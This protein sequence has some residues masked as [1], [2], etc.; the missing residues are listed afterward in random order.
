MDTTMKYKHLFRSFLNKE[1]FDREENYISMPGPGSYELDQS[2]IERRL[3][4]SYNKSRAATRADKTRSAKGISRNN[5][6]VKTDMTFTAGFAHGKSRNINTVNT[7]MVIVNNGRDSYIL[8]SQFQTQKVGPGDYHTNVNW[9]E[10]SYL[11]KRKNE[12]DKMKHN[13]GPKVF[14]STWSIPSRKIKNQNFTGVGND[15]PGPNSYQ[16]DLN[17]I[18]R[19]QNFAPFW[20]LKSDRKGMS[21]TVS[22]IG[23]GQY[24]ALYKAKKNFHV[25][26]ASSMFLSKVKRS[27]HTSKKRKSKK[28]GT[29]TS[30][31]KNI[32]TDYETGI[33]G[34]FKYF[35]NYLII[36]I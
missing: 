34:N 31:N 2:S 29:N 17:P 20:K 24:N 6:N 5:L 32:L 12:Y 7:S 14:K 19:S 8:N 22:E 1:R 21:Q 35:C 26:G 4:T 27:E 10:K 13:E 9:L 3:N 30:S 23:P 18:K 15:K 16:P 36:L 25:T 28:N 33:D 11:V